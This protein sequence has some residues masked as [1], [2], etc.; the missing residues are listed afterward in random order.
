MEEPYKILI[1]NNDGICPV[2]GEYFGEFVPYFIF[3][4]YE[5]SIFAN[6][7]GN[8]KIIGSEKKHFFAR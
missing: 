1:L 7:H 8:V 2:S 6:H 4:L 3:G 5:E